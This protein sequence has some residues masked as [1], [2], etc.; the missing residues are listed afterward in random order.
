[1]IDLND[2]DDPLLFRVQVPAGSLIAQWNEV[3]AALA[4]PGAAE[5]TVQDV[6]AAI[7]KV[8]RTPAVAADTPDEILF[9]AFARMS[10]A[11]ERAGN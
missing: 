1:M 5:P 2:E 6:A 11:V 9:A 7:R 8:S 3:L 10:K 4:K